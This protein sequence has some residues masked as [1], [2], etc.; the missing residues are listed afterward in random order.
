LSGI[1]IS[2]SGGYEG[3]NQ[4]LRLGGNGGG[5]IEYS[6]E[7]YWI[8]DNFIIRY[9]GNTLL[10]TGF[11]GGS[12]S[13]RI[14]VPKGNSNTAQII[15]ATNDEGTAWHYTV[16][17]YVCP[18]TS[19]FKIELAGGA[20]FTH[21]VG[22]NG[23]MVC[24]GTGTIYIGR[25]D[26]IAR[27]LRV[28]GSVEFDKNGMKLNG[29]VFSEI[30]AG[31]VLTKPLFTGSFEVP[32]RTGASS[33]F[34]ETTGTGEYQ[35]GGMDVEFSSIS[36]NRNSVSLGASFRL[37]EELGTPD[38]LFSGP[39]GLIITQNDVTFGHSI[40]Y[41]L[42]NFEDF[43]LFGFVP[44]KEFSDFSIEYIA[45]QDTV[46]IQGKLVVDLSSKP[47]QGEVTA[48]LAGPNFIQIKGGEVDLIGELTVQTDLK[49]PP[50]GWGLKELK[51]T[52]DT[53]NR[54]VG[55]GAKL[56]L[57]IGRTVSV[58]GDIGFKLPIPPLELNKLSLSVD[59]LNLP[60]PSWPGV[61]FQGF[62]GAAENFAESDPDPI[63]FSG[64]V[65]ATLGPQILGI[66]AI[67]VDVDGKLS[68][69]QLVGT[70]TVTV[71]NDKLF[72][73]QVTATLN[74]EKKFFE[75]AGNFNF[76]DGLIQ[77]SS[78]FKPNSNFDITMSGAGKVSIPKSVPLFGGYEIA[79][80]N[81]LIDF[82]NDGNLS[83]DFGAGWGEI[84]IQKLGLDMTFVAGVKVYFDG[85]IERIGAK[86][87]L[88]IGSWD[89]QPDTEWAILG[90]DWEID[91]A[92]DVPV[93]VKKPDGSWI[94][95]ADFAA[96]NI[97]VVDELTDSNSKVVVLFAPAPGI[98]DLEV[99]DPTGL[100]TVSYS[101][102]EE[103]VAPTIMVTTPLVNVPGGAVNIAYTAADADSDAEV[104]LFYDTDNTGLDGVLIARGLPE[105]D[106][107]GSYQWNTQGVAVGD[108]YVYAM[109]TDGDN[110]PVYSYSIGMVQVTEAAD[111]AAAQRVAPAPVYVGNNVTYT[112]TAANAGPSAAVDVT[113]TASLG[114]AVMRSDTSSYS[115][116]SLDPT[117]E[118]V[119]ATGT[120]ILVGVDDDTAEI[121]LPFTFSFYG[122]DYNSVF[123]SSNGLVTFGSATTAY[124]NSDLSS[125]PTQPAIAVLWDDLVTGADGVRW[126]VRGTGANR[127]LVVQWQNAT[128]YG[129]GD[130][131][132]V[133]QVVL[134]EGSNQ[135]QL[136]YANLSNSSSEH[137]EGASATAG[138]KGIGSAPL[139]LAYNNGPNA[140]V[141]SN[142]STLIRPAAFDDWYD[143]AVNA[144]D[145]L[146]FR[147]TTPSETLDPAL[148]LFS[149]GGASLATNSNG[150][151]DGR[152]ARIAYT[153]TETGVYRVRVSAEGGTSGDYF[154]DVTLNVGTLTNGQSRSFDVTLDAPAAPGTMESRLEVRGT[155][156][157][158]FVLNDVDNLTTVV[159]A[160]AVPPP[161][162]EVLAT[163]IPNTAIRQNFTY[164][165]TV[166]NNGIGPATNVVLTT[167]LPL[168]QANFVNTQASQGSTRF[169]QSQGAVVTNF[170]TIAAGETATVQI[171]LFAF[172]AGN[173][174]STVSLSSAEEDADSRNNSLIV[175]NPV[176]T[177]PPTPVDLEL[178]MA[179]NNNAPRYGDEVMIEVT[180]TNQGPGIASGVVVTS[181]LPPSL[182]FVS[183]SLEQGTYDSASGIWYVGNIRDALSR[184]LR[185]TAQVVGGGTIT[186][187]AE[188]A[189]TAE[190]DTDSTPNNGIPTEDDFATLSFLITGNSPP[191]LDPIG[192][193]SVNVGT[194]LAFQVTASDPD[195]P[196]NTLALSAT[197][198]PAGA[199]FDPATGVFSW[200]PSASQL[201]KYQVKFTVTD[202]GTPALSDTETITIVVNPVVELPGGKGV[203]QAKVVRK[204]DNLQVVL[205]KRVLFNQ[206]LDLFEQL[207]IRGAANKSDQVTIDLSGGAFE[208]AGG[209]V[210]DGGLGTQT[211]T[212]TLR[213]TA[214]GNIFQLLPS[215]TL[216]INGVTY[217]RATLDGVAVYFT[218]VEQTILDGGAGDDE[219][220]VA[221][222]GVRT[223]LSDSKG[224]DLLDFSQ[225]TEGV[226]IDLGKSSGQGQKVFPSSEARLALMGTFENVV[227]TAYADWIK[228]NKAANWIVGNDGDDT[229]YGDA[230]NDTLFGNAGN[231]WLYGDAGNDTLYGGP[232]NN[233]LLGGSGNDTL[234]VFDGD[235]A[236]RNLLIGGLGADVLRG[237][238]GEEILIGGTTKYDTKAAAIGKIMEEWTSIRPFEE[239]WANLER[240]IDGGKLGLIQLVRKTKTAPKGMVFDDK[241]RDTLFGSERS[242]WFLDFAKDE[243]QDRGIGD[244]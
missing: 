44:I 218:G 101:A 32:F 10:E 104:Q 86:N 205:G 216:L 117:F 134:F 87:I 110:P 160:M 202:D 12:R 5:T 16:T 188:V 73:G 123:V 168:G 206:P 231:D 176:D 97:A 244:H 1:S 23:D 211:D 107:P 207:T 174:I 48:N 2:D 8:P 135:I 204:G 195:L 82:S 140:Y 221:E 62:R 99:V 182:Q 232:G 63:E 28:N 215:G 33:S 103:S 242:D 18:D 116:L 235:A 39:D 220:R 51:F 42:P 181:L 185:I 157:D 19:P 165:L 102:A 98:W 189:D 69:E 175:V 191:V 64:G 236:D 150:A 167:L 169:S 172:A 238:A 142:K 34:S 149:P 83:N 155:T 61:F 124:R 227:G 22:P 109:V 210:F 115:A 126:E 108:Y 58:A 74:W 138:I 201:G 13:G 166:R 106:G 145:A 47:R 143:V 76:L 158:P 114:P 208:L 219:Y 75:A 147:T 9:D 192:D 111:L 177:L 59:N 233:V 197:N 94:E 77:A 35:L 153:A 203:N 237:G 183:A 163:Q 230:G 21:T 40:K 228:G 229:L 80:G 146:V 112:F 14:Q 49:F 159:E 122:A 234:D 7:H 136:N 132:L 212:L 217:N 141:G 67:R 72:Q 119:S 53:I 71:V 55:G 152:N 36:I 133:F 200:T 226:T 96:N 45:P 164:E 194:E 50:K 184:T 209:I 65:S 20:E 121:P 128:F 15:V 131:T 180:L 243:V 125:S 224:I 178:A 223:R 41:S 137:N 95:E 213:G 4:T 46:K 89:I 187:T 118:D 225:A 43:N 52:I 57:P 37:P 11:V 113:A 139:L 6:Y 26:G 100:G 171:T 240:G 199:T 31:E 239:R 120:Q 127:R 88:P 179:V 81:Y 148:E 186:V 214:A 151:G 161:E 68:S 70:G 24:H 130:S 54:D 79:S 144:G 154:L 66:S 129:G 196:P 156:F 170:G 91:A 162:L 38:F 56:T 3:S 193:K 105:A 93:R 29:T 27:M 60:I 90:A 85:R 30:G 78:S 25:I 92:G 190:P 222:L 17:A 241:T 198:L 84:R 173:L